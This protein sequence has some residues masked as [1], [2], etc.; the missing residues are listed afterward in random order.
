ME[1]D[2][3]LSLLESTPSNH[4]I[5]A[6]FQAIPKSLFDLLR[7]LSEI[8]TATTSPANPSRLFNSTVS[9]SS[10]HQT[11]SRSF[12]NFYGFIDS[13]PI[14]LFSFTV[15]P[16]VVD[17]DCNLTKRYF[18]IRYFNYIQ[19]YAIL[20]PLDLKEVDIMD[21]LDSLDINDEFV[22]IHRTWDYL[23]EQPEIISSPTSTTTSPTKSP[24]RFSISGIKQRSSLSSPQKPA[25]P[26]K[27]EGFEI[28]SSTPFIGI[29]H[30]FNIRFPHEIRAFDYNH[31]N[32]LIA[33]STHSTIFLINSK[34]GMII[35]EYKTTTTT[36]KIK[37]IQ[38]FDI[39]QVID[40]V[41]WTNTKINIL[42]NVNHVIQHD[43]NEVID[44]LQYSDSVLVIA[45][46]K[47][48]IILDKID[49]SNWKSRFIQIDYKITGLHQIDDRLMVQCNNV[50]TVFDKFKNLFTVSCPGNWNNGGSLYFLDGKVYCW[51]EKEFSVYQV[52]CMKQ[53]TYK[54]VG[55][56]HYT[57]PRRVDLNASVDDNAFNEMREK[58]HERTERLVNV[59]EVGRKVEEAGANF[60]NDTE[61]L[62]KQQAAKRW[63]S[64]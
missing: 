4:P 5:K 17:W 44:F 58:F 16:G 43:D 50:L 62:L 35:N 27:H 11:S 64:L 41:L 24:K 51:A 23:I 25:P 18:S 7:H 53:G 42:S 21:Q 26:E 15:Q 56:I 54:I 38:I 36:L 28:T 59:V 29:N 9:L 57:S 49:I 63:F 39:D 45:C 2:Y 22:E 8:E 12:I 13:C 10:L 46:E 31:Y 37:L 48:L 32:S 20:S 33:I 55:G 1:Y 6:K 19:V 52:E 40:C 34:S 30:L 14:L 3:S 60:R 47:S 61:K